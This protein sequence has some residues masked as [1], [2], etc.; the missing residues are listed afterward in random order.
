MDF[1]FHWHLINFK[2]QF[3]HEPLLNPDPDK[4]TNKRI[5]GKIQFANKEFMR[6]TR[7]PCLRK[8]SGAPLRLIKTAT[9]CNVKIAVITVCNYTDVT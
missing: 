6:N 8:P 9:C 7:T 3:C 5:H 1:N 2:G 4:D